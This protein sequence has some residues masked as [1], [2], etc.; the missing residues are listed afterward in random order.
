MTARE[1][2]RVSELPRQLEATAE[3]VD[4]GRLLGSPVSRS[5]KRQ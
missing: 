5:E 2:E 4:A 1:S 3:P